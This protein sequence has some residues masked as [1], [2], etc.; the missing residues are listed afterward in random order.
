MTITS[1]LIKKTIHSKQYTQVF[2]IIQHT[3]SVFPNLLDHMEHLS[4]PIFRRG[5]LDTQFDY[6][7]LLLY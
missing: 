2:I 4:Q 1:L 5:I 3:K 6:I 7:R